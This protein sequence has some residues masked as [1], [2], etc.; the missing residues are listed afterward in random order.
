ML[1]IVSV[2]IIIIIIDLNFNLN[3]P[4][5]YAVQQWLLLNNFLK[6]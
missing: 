6:M 2:D 5:E 1:L 3:V 4:M